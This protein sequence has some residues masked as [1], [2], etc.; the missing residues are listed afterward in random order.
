[1]TLSIGI[2]GLLLLV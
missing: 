2:R 1:V